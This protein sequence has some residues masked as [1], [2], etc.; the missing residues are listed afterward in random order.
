[1]RLK[2]SLNLCK[3]AKYL[4]YESPYILFRQF[5]K[6]YNSIAYPLHLKIYY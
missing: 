4:G 2:D 5:E 6:V 3:Y 1:M